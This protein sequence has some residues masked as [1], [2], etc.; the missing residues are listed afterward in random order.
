MARVPMLI[1]AHGKTRSNTWSH[2]HD[3]H[4]RLHH[5]EMSITGQKDY[6]CPNSFLINFGG[7]RIFAGG[8]ERIPIRMNSNSKYGLDL[9]SGNLGGQVE[10]M[11][12][13]AKPMTGMNW[14]RTS[15][16]RQDA[17]MHQ[18]LPH[19]ALRMGAKDYARLQTRCPR[20]DG[21]NKLHA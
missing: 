2:E 15:L 12:E 4:S 7:N 21:C 17:N 16:A 19:H 1:Q 6:V 20:M 9:G 18:S 5:T 10:I 8:N 13:S 11:S 3:S 14:S